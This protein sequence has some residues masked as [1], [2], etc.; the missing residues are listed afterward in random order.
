MPLV[1]LGA[2]LISFAPVF[3]KLLPLPAT[4]IGF[5]RMAFGL[6]VLLLWSAWARQ[7]LRWQSKTSL[8]ALVAG[9]F[10]AL[11]VVFWH[12]SIHIIGPGLATL[13]ANCQ[14]F[15]VTTFGILILGEKPGPR[16]WLAIPLA[17]LGLI[18]VVGAHWQHNPEIQSGVILGFLAALSYAGYLLILRQAEKSRKDPEATLFS[19]VMIW[20]TLG[21]LLVLAGLIPYQHISLRVEMPQ[22]LLLLG[23]YGILI[24]GLAWV[25]I[26]KGLPRIPVSLGGLLLL[27]Q[28]ALAFVWDVIFFHRPTS[29]REICGAL[30]TLLAIYL[31]SQTRYKAST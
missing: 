19:P 20:A 18:M 21:S 31:G 12:Q 4:V 15:F 7:S 11:D 14:V 1:I 27:L 22:Q 8:L 17:I 3:V 30:L 10:F 5:Y 28:P 16:L 9:V 25:L 13:L 6:A 26:S 24:Q 23:L 29:L 2:L